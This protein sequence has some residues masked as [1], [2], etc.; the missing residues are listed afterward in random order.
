MSPAAAII[1][2]WTCDSTGA[3]CYS[4]NGRTVGR[5]RDGFDAVLE[6]VRHNPEAQVILRGGGGALGGE[7]LA[8]TTPFAD[9][10]PELVEALG[11]RSLTWDLL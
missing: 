6:T 9:R 3:A 4:V 7:D 11:G 2:G 5:D 1:V 10:F 8:D